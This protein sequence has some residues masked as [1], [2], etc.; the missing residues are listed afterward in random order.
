MIIPMAR[1]RIMGPR[2][3]LDPTLLAVQDAGTVHLATAPAN[4]PLAPLELSERA[5]RHARQLRELVRRLDLLGVAGAK[6]VPGSPPPTRPPSTAE[7]AAWVRATRRFERSKDRLD[8]RARELDSERAE[9]ARFEQFVH[10]FRGMLPRGSDGRT[11]AYQLVIR[12]EDEDQVPRLRSALEEV[13]GREFA[14]E[15]S[16]M[17]NGELAVLLLAPA[18]TAPMVE[19]LLTESGVHELPLPRGVEGGPLLEALPT[20]A[21]RREALDLE[22]AALERERA[23]LIRDV[24]PELGRAR[25]A[26]GDHLL[27]LEARTRAATTARSFLVEGWAPVAAL[28][29]L[30]ELLA[31]RVGSEVVLETVAKEEWR[32]ED[33]PVALANPRL[34]RP[35]ETLT[36]MLPLPKYGT[37]DPTPYTAVFFPMFFGLILG[38]IGY[39]LVLGLLALLLRRRSG[40][41]TTLRS[42]SEILGAGALFAVLFG[43]GF[44]ELFGD[45]GRRWFGLEPLVFDREASLI[46]F[47]VL[48]IGIGLVHVGLG[49]VLGIINAARG[50]PR[51]ALGRTAALLML[52]FVTVA[53]LAAIEVLPGALLTPAMVV[54]LV[55]FPVLVAAEGIIA[56]IEFLGTV[57]NVLSY[58]RIMAL[59]TASV[60]MA[61]VA[62]ELAGSVGSVVVGVLFGLLFHLV[63]F[64]LGVFAPTVHGLRLHYVEFFGKFFSPGGTRYTPFGH[65]RPNGTP[66]M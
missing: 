18:T 23:E 24:V 33:A 51:Q 64:V 50:H 55:A 13:I 44:G 34:F 58:A 25:A 7:L 48:A 32:G 39:G 20:L 11:R 31:A 4:G 63:N 59:G 62:N 1:V 56:P 21:A 41:G 52:V 37:I 40:P 28:P 36:S 47:L 8:H 53:L 10:A 61:V 17:P 30:G 9:I 54:V 19:R 43:F 45:L 26:V 57:S 35:F 22:R 14:L 12:A 60:M 5:G 65:W 66:T 38:D 27:E 15:S 3:L 46:P 42:V 29:K 16:P 49:L 2:A 6:P